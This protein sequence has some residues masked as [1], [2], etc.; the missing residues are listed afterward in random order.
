VTPGNPTLAWVGEKG[1]EVVIPANVTARM[2]PQER[3]DAI[4]GRGYGQGGS[5]GMSIV[6]AP[7]PEQAQRISREHMD[8]MWIDSARRNIHRVTR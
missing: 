1:P 5:G 7:S 4:S 2:S 3:A 8:A 6:V